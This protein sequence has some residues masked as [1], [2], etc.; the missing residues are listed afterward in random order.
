[1]E[2]GFIFTP[3]TPQT[4]STTSPEV[5]DP[6]EHDRHLRRTYGIIGVYQVEECEDGE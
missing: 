2:N 3:T 1:M 6:G 5:Y 4:F